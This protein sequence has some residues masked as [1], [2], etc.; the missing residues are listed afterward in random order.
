MDK[1]P[2]P[3]SDIQ[4]TSSGAGAF[5]R[6]PGTWIV[7][8]LF[9]GSLAAGALVEPQAAAFGLGVTLLVGLF[10]SPAGA[11]LRERFFGPGI[12]DESQDTAWKVVIPD[13][14]MLMTELERQLARAV[15]YGEDTTLVVAQVAKRDVLVQAHG[16]AG[17]AAAE[18]QL[19]E[20]LERVTRTSD[21]MAR[22]DE[23]RYAVLLIQCPVARADRYIERMTLAA[24]N[25][26]VLVAGSRQP[27]QVN[28]ES[29]AVQFDARRHQHPETFLADALTGPRPGLQADGHLESDGARLRQMIFG[30]SREARA[31][32][33]R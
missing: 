16:K 17:L 33:V 6:R 28:V 15:R 3:I 10:M 11:R 12:V 30:E 20:T 8:A 5:A 32:S 23:G 27:F 2:A 24:R 19:V 1:L 29:H 26:S 13:R 22:L 14:R 9:A 4:T 25:R 18:R 21:Y 7:A 31:Q